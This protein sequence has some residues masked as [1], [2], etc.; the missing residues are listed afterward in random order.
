MSEDQ[1]IGPGGD[2]PPGGSD[3]LRRLLAVLAAWTST[4]RGEWGQAMLAELDEI[5][6]TRDRWRFALGSARAML[7]PAPV[8][9]LVLIPL[10]MTAAGALAV[11]FLIPIAGSTWGI[12]VPAA[13]CLCAWAAMGRPAGR[14]APA[15]LSRAG[16]VIALALI[17]A[18][19]ALAIR[20]LTLYPG[21]SGSS[22]K[23]G[24]A[25]VMSIVLV[26]YL[27]A[28]ALLV[29]RR[30][31]PLG[32]WRYSGLPGLAAALATG[33]V[34]LLNQ[35]PGGQSDNP[36][37]NTAV[38]ATALAAAPAAG[39]LAAL[40]H[41]RRTGTGQRLRSA[42]GEMAWGWLLTAPAVFIALML[43]TTTSA[44]TAE[45]ALPVFINEAHQQ[46]AT[47]VLAW[48]S[49]D[50]LGGALV[51]FAG[52]SV[53]SMLIFLVI[54]ALSLVVQ[55]LPKLARRRPDTPIAA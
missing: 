32:G 13:P 30:P 29:L 36:V 3:G 2:G 26:A 55:A 46:G 7:R 15:V 38:V 27:A 35:P 14:T 54:H 5:A 6:G 8:S 53:L 31:G 18:V 9:P 40:L 34:F 43:T 23:P 51:M 48:V 37:V 50:D 45:A 28:L 19:P 4:G 10:A 11:R 47:S 21:S 22:P 33:G 12:A 17:A 41:R 1:V 25:L 39:V 42:A 24:A 16:Q 44:I 49:S 20:L 52:L